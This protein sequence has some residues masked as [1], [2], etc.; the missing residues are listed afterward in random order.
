MIGNILESLMF[1]IINTIR[2]LSYFGVFILTA[3][4]SACIPIPSEVIMPFSGFL[5]AQGYFNFILVVLVATLGELCGGTIAYFIGKTGGRRLVE[6]YGK[7]ILISHHDLNKADSWFQKYGDKTVFFGRLLP[8]I[9][10]Y[11]SFPAGVSKMKY[12]RF[13][14]FTV[15]GTLPWVIV[16]TYLGIKLGNNWEIIRIYFHKFD[17]L[18]LILIIIGLIWYVWRHIKNIR[19]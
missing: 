16:L 4:E 8:I 5:V 14:I 6:K 10:T 17:I 12:S 13:A 11:I 15:L 7:Y 2:A 18:I 19:K 1:F 9:R 3:A